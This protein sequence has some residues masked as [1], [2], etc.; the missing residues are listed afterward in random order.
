MLKKTALWAVGFVQHLLSARIASTNGF[1]VVDPSTG[2]PSHVPPNASAMWPPHRNHPTSKR[3][4]RRYRGQAR[5]INEAM[6]RGGQKVPVQ[7]PSK[8]LHASRTA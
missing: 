4:R 7:N 3:Q 1:D 8:Y 6:K 5:T 2:E